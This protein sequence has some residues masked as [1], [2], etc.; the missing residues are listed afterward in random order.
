MNITDPSVGF[1]I[2]VIAMVSI[3]IIIFIAMLIMDKGSDEE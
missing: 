2:V 1:P 3:A